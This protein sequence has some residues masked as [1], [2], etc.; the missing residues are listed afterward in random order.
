MTLN[1]AIPVLYTEVKPHQ[2]CDKNVVLGAIKQKG[3]NRIA[4]IGLGHQCIWEKNPG[5]INN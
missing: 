5:F 1:I 2:W 3:L 4:K